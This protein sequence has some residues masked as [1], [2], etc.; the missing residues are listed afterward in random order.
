MVP[1]LLCYTF[2]ILHV[3]P[4][5]CLLDNSEMNQLVVIKATKN[6]AFRATV[7]AIVFYMHLSCIFQL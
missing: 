4:N 7:V 6:I 2:Y 1:F 5:H 3:P